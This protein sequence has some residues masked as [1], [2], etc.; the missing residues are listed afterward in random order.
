MASDDES[1]E[2][3]REEVSSVY[4]YYREQSALPWWR[5]RRDP[6]VHSLITRPPWAEIIRGICF[7]CIGTALV[8]FGC[9]IYTSLCLPF[10]LLLL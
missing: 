10:F 1:D 6:M 5:R 7:L 2:E 9:L 4:K 3:A 8:T